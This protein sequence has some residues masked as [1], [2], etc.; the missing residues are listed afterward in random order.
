MDPRRDIRLYRSDP[1]TLSG[2]MVSHESNLVG[3]STRFVGTS[4]VQTVKGISISEETLVY[5]RSP[6][7]QNP[8]QGDVYESAVC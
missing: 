2:R 8:T 7:P 6:Y 4:Q 5:I 3:E 1:G